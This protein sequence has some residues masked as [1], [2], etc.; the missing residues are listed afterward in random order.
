MKAHCYRITVQSLA[1]DA[2]LSFDVEQHDDL[3]R[4]VERVRS[5]GAFDADAAALAVGAKLLTGVMLRH[6]R[7]PL[8]AGLQPAMRT[9]IGNLKARVDGGESA[10]K[11]PE[12]MP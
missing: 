11:L 1:Q 9:F 7:D 3:L 2:G 8:F 12:D 10:A 6:R 4:I 5:S